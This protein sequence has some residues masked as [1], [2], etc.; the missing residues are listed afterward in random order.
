MAGAQV[1]KPGKSVYVQMGIWYNEDT[2]EIHLTA[3]G[4]EG[5]HTTVNNKPDSIRGH[6]N[7]FG[8]L[9]KLLAAEGAPHPQVEIVD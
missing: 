6:K 1:S 8:K 4:V 5:F 9:A 2:K 7:L 3:Q